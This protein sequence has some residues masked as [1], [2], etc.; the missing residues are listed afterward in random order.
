M[1]I[2]RLLA[3]TILLLNRRKVTAVQLAE[4]FEVS[5]R[6]IYRDFE[7]LNAAGIPIISSQGYEGGFCIPDNF[8][9]SRQILTYTDMVSIVTTL[10]G[11]N[12][13]LK[14]REIDRVIEKITSLIPSEKLEQFEKER[15]QFV[16]DISPWYSPSGVMKILEILHR[17]VAE[18]RVLRFSYTKLNGYETQR[19]VEPHTLV[20]K[21]FNWYLLAYCHLRDNFRVF[22]LSRISS[23]EMLHDHFL[24]R[25]VRPHDFF[26]MEPNTHTPSAECVLLFKSAVRVRVMEI[27]SEEQITHLENGMLEV[28]FPATEDEWITSFVLSFGENAEIVSPDHWR[29][30]IM[31]TIRSIQYIYR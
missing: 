12:S 17:G 16:I 4:H 1:K 7:T 18:S 24:R 25:S 20:Y 6:T 19:T 2:A 21:S 14:N 28:R 31:K 10:Q 3:I 11:V 15:D 8:K 26:D 5:Q 22:R 29:K 13:S 23:L 27:F 9:L 30:K